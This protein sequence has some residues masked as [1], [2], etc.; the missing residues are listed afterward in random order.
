VLDRLLEDGRL[1]IE[2]VSGTS[3]GAINGALLVQ[4]FHGGGRPGARAALDRF[5]QRIS[6]LGW[7]SPVHRTWLERLAG[8][9]NLDDT[10]GSVLFDQLARVLSPYQTNPLNFSPLRGLLEESVDAA[11]LRAADAIKLFVVATRVTS[12]EPRIFDHS[13]VSVDALLASACLPQ[14]FQAV[15]IDG[16]PYWDGGYMG[17]PTLRPLMRRC[18]A[19][20]IVI[21]EVNPIRR[22]GVPRSAAE[23]MN[24]LNEITFNAALLAELRQIALMDHV[25][26]RAPHAAFDGVRC[27]HVHMIEAERAMAALGV[28]S[29]LNTDMDFLLHLKEVGRRTAERWLAE[30]FDAI[31]VRSTLDLEKLLGE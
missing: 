2:G 22:P 11:T 3:A 10:P 24:R 6:E 13:D 14:L 1:R 23:I 21:V 15:M 12:G 8:T 25:L 29:K 31:G 26:D 18:A 20:D 16:E 5:W 9:W 4:G 27:L 28:T 30:N 17:N 7:L 19:P